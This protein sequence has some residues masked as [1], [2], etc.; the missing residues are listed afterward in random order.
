MDAEADIAFPTL[1][2]FSPPVQREGLLQEVGAYVGGGERL[3]ILTTFQG[4][5]K[6]PGRERNWKAWFCVETTR[7][8]RKLP[9]PLSWGTR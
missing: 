4:V 9:A 6:Y 5:V 7:T 2:R 8:L 3:W 1:G